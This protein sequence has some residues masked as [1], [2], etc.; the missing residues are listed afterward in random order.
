MS[1][2]IDTNSC[3]PKSDKLYVAPFHW[4]ASLFYF[5]RIHVS[6]SV[7]KVVSGLGYHRN[8]HQKLLKTHNHQLI[9]DLVN[10][11]TEQVMSTSLL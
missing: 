4:L 10:L 5:T 9:Y 11:A 3:R 6:C 1:G 7:L 8:H 2:I